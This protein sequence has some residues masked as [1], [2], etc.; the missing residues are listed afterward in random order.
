MVKYII[1]RFVEMVLTLFIIATATFFL[2]EAVPGDP[3]TQ[4]ADHLPQQSR[5]ALYARYGLD[6][7]VMERY[8]TQMGNMLHGEFGESFVYAGTN[9]QRSFT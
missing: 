3:L 1:R 9:R 5:E 8:L 6:K 2:L 4:R 7:P